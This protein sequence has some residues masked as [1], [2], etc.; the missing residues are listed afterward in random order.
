MLIMTHRAHIVATPSDEPTLRKRDVQRITGWADKT[1]YRKIAD[2]TLPA[3]RIGRTYRFRESDV[4]AL[5]HRISTAAD[6]D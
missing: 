6:F 5:R 4:L 1:I 2:G 3:W